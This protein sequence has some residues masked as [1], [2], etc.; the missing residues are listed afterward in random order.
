IEE[1]ACDAALLVLALTYVADPAAALREMARITRPG[2]RAVVVDLLRHDRDDFR[3]RMGQRWPGFE[4]AE[5]TAM[6]A[7]AGWASVRCEP[8]PPEPAAKGPAL[9]LARATRA[10]GD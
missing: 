10:R 6:L 4:P 8:L 5:L 3:R 1:G 2:G 9:M 7:E